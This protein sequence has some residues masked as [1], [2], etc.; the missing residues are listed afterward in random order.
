M[1]KLRYT[2]GQI[3]FALRQAETSTPV[4]EL[5]DRTKF[6]AADLTAEYGIRRVGRVY[7]RPSSPHNE[8]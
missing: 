6:G 3:A 8:H 4:I 5:I 1:K 7:R 2:D